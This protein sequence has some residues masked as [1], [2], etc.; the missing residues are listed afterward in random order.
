M[1]TQE[2][3]FA[4]FGGQGVLLMGKFLAYAG[5]EAD[6]YVSWLPSYGPEMRGGTCN[7]SV[8]VSDEPVG[9]PIITQPSTIVVMNRPSLD[10]FEPLLKKGGTLIMDRDLVDRAPGRDDIHVISISAQQEAEKIG[11]K[12]I[13]N[14][15]LL[16]ALV[17][18]TGIISIEGI[19]E[20]LKN[21]GKEEFYELNKKAI[22]KGVEYI[23]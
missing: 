14:M 10:K 12:K 4:G 15:V 6:M 1:S 18:K 19:L 9:S 21:Y 2:V 13:A 22:E 16:G 8:I 11:D 5:M 7:C 3:I 17:K 20:A 23:L